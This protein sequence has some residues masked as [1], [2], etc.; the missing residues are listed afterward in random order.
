MIPY[1]PRVLRTLP[2]LLLLA[3]PAFAADPAADAQAFM[4]A[5]G[6]RIR[7]VVGSDASPDAKRAQVEE[8]IEASLDIPFMTR[9]ALGSQAERFSPDELLAFA[10]E[11]ERHLVNAYVRWVARSG[12]GKAEPLGASYD[13]KTGVARVELQGEARGSVYRYPRRG[14]PKPPTQAWRLRRLDG[15]WRI[16]AVSVDGVDITR[17]FREEFASFL[18]RSTPAELVAELR[19]R[20]AEAESSNPFA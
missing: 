3:A 17:S 16:L 15:E 8:V 11:F 12:G 5:A 19:R 20:N 7:S 2:L 10:Q 9:V 4:Q 14:A 13:E 1:R 18:E 6:G